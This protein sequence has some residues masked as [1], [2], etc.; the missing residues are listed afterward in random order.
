MQ[1]APD[2]VR[3]NKVEERILDFVWDPVVLALPQ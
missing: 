2:L 3:Q 1:D